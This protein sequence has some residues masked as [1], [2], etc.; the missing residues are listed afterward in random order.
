MLFYPK[1]RIFVKGSKIPVSSE[2]VQKQSPKLTWEKNRRRFWL[3]IILEFN[4]K[5]K[6]VNSTT[7]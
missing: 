2:H 6:E 3:K 5:Y 4:A 1:I 7:S